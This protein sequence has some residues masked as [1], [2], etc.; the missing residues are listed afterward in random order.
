V[1]RGERGVKRPRITKECQTEGERIRLGAEAASLAVS[2]FLVNCWIPISKVL[3]E[4]GPGGV[5]FDEQRAMVTC[6]ERTGIIKPESGK[7]FPKT[8]RI[9]A[10]WSLD[11]KKWKERLE[12][13]EDCDEVNQKVEEKVET[14]EF[15]LLQTCQEIELKLTTPVMP[16]LASSLWGKG[17]KFLAFSNGFSCTPHGTHETMSSQTVKQRVLRRSAQLIHSDAFQSLSIF[18]GQRGHPMSFAG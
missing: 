17:V 13:L 4:G 8:L 2:D 12:R 1:A 10:V 3:V 15:Y 9:S 11:T 7:N 5:F 14:S 18:D 6:I 16:E